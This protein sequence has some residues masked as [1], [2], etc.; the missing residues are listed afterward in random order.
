MSSARIHPGVSETDVHSSNSFSSHGGSIHGGSIHSSS[1]TPVSTQ[2]S[3]LQ[4]PPKQLVF[5]KLFGISE[6]DLYATEHTAANHRGR[7]PMAESVRTSI[8][9]RKTFDG[10][11]SLGSVPSLEATVEEEEEVELV[12]LNK[13]SS[14]LSEL[15]RHDETA[16]REF[17]ELTTHVY[18]QIKF[19]EAHDEFRSILVDHG[20]TE[21]HGWP[22]HDVDI[23]A[24]LQ[25]LSNLYIT[26]Q[27]KHSASHDTQNKI[28]NIQSLTFCPNILFSNFPHDFSLQPTSRSFASAVLL[29]DISGFSKFAGQMCLRGARGLD[30]LHKVT[31][32]F[33]GHFVHTVYDFDGDGKHNKTIS[34]H[35]ISYFFFSTL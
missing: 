15:K 8:G 31:S 19:N 28:K 18:N 30:T 9:R 25:Q 23:N 3:N 7:T 29:A 17:S 14:T 34:F 22:T 10:M 26:M 33:L 16:W 5:R 6:S 21:R 12:L 2:R 32:D 11:S 4:V 13:V 24:L 35:F 1:S 20:F 27:N